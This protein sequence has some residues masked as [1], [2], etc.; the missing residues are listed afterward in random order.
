MNFNSGFNISS[1]ITYMGVLRRGNKKKSGI[2]NILVNP[3]FTEL[4]D[5]IVVDMRTGRFWR[6]Q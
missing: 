1:A 5:G 3:N 4:Q 6:L 2:K